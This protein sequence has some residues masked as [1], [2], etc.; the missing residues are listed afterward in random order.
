[1][2]DQL[3]SGLLFLDDFAPDKEV[4]CNLV[5]NLKVWAMKQKKID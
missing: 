5:E 2:K 1:M 4:P 3:K